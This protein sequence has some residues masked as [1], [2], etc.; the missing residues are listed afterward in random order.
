[1]K[2]GYLALVVI[3]LWTADVAVAQSAGT[4]A[5]QQR[6]QVE[7]PL[8]VPTVELESANPFVVAV[9]QAPKLLRSEA[10]RKVEVRGLATVAA[11]VDA[12]GVCLG[13]V[14]LTQP[15]PGLTSSLTQ[16]LT[17]S[18]FDTARTGTVPQPSWVVLEIGMAG[19]VKESS[20]V[21]LVLSPPDPSGPPAPSP[22]AKMAPPGNLLDLPFTPLEE[23]TSVA[24]PRRVRIHSPGREADV[25][26]R[27]LVH[28]TEQGRCDRYVPL[29]LYDGL[30]PWLSAFLA[31][32]H[33]QAATLDGSPA[34]AWMVLS[35]QVRLKL[36]GIESISLKVARDRTYDP[37]A[38]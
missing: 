29:E 32:W 14:P 5:W 23:L 37:S 38:P 15:F 27:A 19:R 7:I 26:I 13:A 2:R 12:K 28:I 20:I 33:V 1:M 18:R 35:A 17:G 10:P 3:L 6:L 8:P 22:T 30:N 25:R 21:D 4:R 36:S 9:D 16:E 11:Y 31:T 24:S 34:A